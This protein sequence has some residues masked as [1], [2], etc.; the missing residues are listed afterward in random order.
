M[1]TPSF[2]SKARWLGWGLWLLVIAGSAFLYTSSRY[3]ASILQ[4]DAIRERVAELAGEFPTSTSGR[5]RIVHFLDP[6]C[7]CT[8]FTLE[9]LNTL[10]PL[11]RS[12]AADQWLIS[13][14]SDSPSAQR[15]AETLGATVLPARMEL[16]VGPAIAIW[17]SQGRLAYFG[18]YSLSMVCGQDQLLE[19]ILN[20]IAVSGWQEAPYS[21]ETGCFCPWSQP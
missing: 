17:D 10:Q 5:V 18:P 3:S 11:L 7:A 4:D 16:R 2:A 21:I 14:E 8:P 13:P 9:H 6:S 1:T 19:K 20:Q 12:L 15:L